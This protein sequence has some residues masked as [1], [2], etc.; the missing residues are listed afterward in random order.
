MPAHDHARTTT[1]DPDRMLGYPELE[2]LIR[3]PRGTLYCWVH[4][5][6]IP[7]VRLGPRLVRF[8]LSEVVAWLDQR[9]VAAVG[10]GSK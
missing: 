8:R 2:A 3:I 9:A 4:Q 1:T 5:R 10:G 7:H 6:A